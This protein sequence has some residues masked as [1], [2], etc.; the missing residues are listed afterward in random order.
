MLPHVALGGFLAPNQSLSEDP[1]YLKADTLVITLPIDNFFNKSKL[2][3]ALAWEK[4]FNAFMLEY[5]NPALDIAYRSERSIEDELERMSKSDV[6][7]VIISYVIMF[8]YIALALGRTDHPSKLLESTKVTLGLGGVLIVL[9]SVFAAVGLYGFA[10][11]PCTM[12]IIEVIP[13]LVL[14]V[15][16]DNIFILVEAYS[17]LDT[18]E[19]SQLN[20]HARDRK[21]AQLMGKAV[22]E[23]GPSMLLSSLSQAC[24][25]FLGALSDMPAVR[26]FA[27]YA[28]M[29]LL[30]NFVL[31]MS[32]FV[33]LFSLD[34]RR[35]EANRIDVMCCIKKSKKLDSEQEVRFLPRVFEENYAPFLMRPCVRA[36]VVVVFFF[37]VCAS[38]AM[39]PHINVGL[40]EELSMPDDSYV[41]KYFE[42]SSLEEIKFSRIHSFMARS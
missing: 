1:N 30:I 34:V 18:S 13:F 15:G 27:L 24:C 39:V 35:E 2:E 6:P 21:R 23:V 25:F 37:W 17:G 29:S 36:L 40:E 32:L 42:V 22:G 28:G 4:A 10:G 16:V 12:L 11:V 41:L 5:D 9:L 8:I 26:A 19:L 31:Q 33:A 20:G 38:I 3:P 14:A 7:T